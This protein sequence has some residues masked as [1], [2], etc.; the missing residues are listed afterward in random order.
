MREEVNEFK[1]EK[2]NVFSYMQQRKSCGTLGAA[3]QKVPKA[4]SVRS[5]STL[6]HTSSNFPTQPGLSR[7]GA[8]RVCTLDPNSFHTGPDCAGPR[9]GVPKVAS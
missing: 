3:Q 6:L 9:N 1:Y 7:L 4:A 8:D 2:S 5:E